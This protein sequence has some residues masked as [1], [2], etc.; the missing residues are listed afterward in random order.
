MP[1]NKYTMKM[2]SRQIDG[3]TT[4]RMDSY[5]MQYNYAMRNDTDPKKKSKRSGVSSINLGPKYADQSLGNPTYVKPGDTVNVDPDRI[6]FLVNKKG[7]RKPESVS[8]SLTLSNY[9]YDTKDHRGSF[10]NAKFKRAKEYYNTRYL[11]K[12]FPK[13]FE[14]RN[15]LKLKLVTPSD[16]G[17]VRTILPYSK[18][19]GN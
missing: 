15:L 8:D 10:D 16:Q 1:K 4:F 2:G 18:R 11:E 3:D 5:A 17:Y 7:L 19:S 13:S 9:V 12:N 14:K 6:D